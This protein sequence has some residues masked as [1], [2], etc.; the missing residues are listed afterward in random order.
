MREVVTAGGGGSAFA[1]QLKS[2]DD[3]REVT[4]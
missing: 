2:L 4:D 1:S 3:G